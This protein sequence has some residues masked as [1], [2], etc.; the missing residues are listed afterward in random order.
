MITYE[1]TLKAKISYLKKIRAV[2]KSFLTDKRLG[3]QLKE[4][5][6]IEYKLDGSLI[7]KLISSRNMALRDYKKISKKKIKKQS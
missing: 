5:I 3:K 2:N 1:Q 4:K 6:K 7:K